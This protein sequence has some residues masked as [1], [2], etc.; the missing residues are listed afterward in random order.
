MKSNWKMNR[1]AKGHIYTIMNATQADIAKLE[2]IAAAR[3]AEGDTLAKVVYDE[4]G[5]PLFFTQDEL[6]TTIE[7]EFNSKG[8]G[9]YVSGSLIKD[10]KIAYET[11]KNPALQGLRGQAFLTAEAQI[12]AEKAE[13]IKKRKPVEEKE[14]E[15]ANLNP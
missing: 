4:A 15:N 9:V 8:T 7:L 5:R 3:R 1:G 11:E 13:L 6:E 10:L 14:Q 12:R 2:E